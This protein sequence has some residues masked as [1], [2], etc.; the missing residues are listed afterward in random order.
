MTQPFPIATAPRDG[1]TV[2]VFLAGEDIWCRAFWARMMQ[3][4]VCERDPD[5]RAL[6]RVTL[7][8]LEQP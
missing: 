3:A 4:W 5:M 2:W 6:R 7:W 8:R 1:T